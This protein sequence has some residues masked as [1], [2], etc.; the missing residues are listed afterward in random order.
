MRRELLGRPA[1]GGS[2]ARS[3]RS[4]TARH[5]G[6]STARPAAD[7]RRVLREG[8]RLED[9]AA[10]GRST[11]A[12]SAPPPS[13]RP[14]NT[15]QRHP[16]PRPSNRAG[17]RTTPRWRARRPGPGG[18]RRELHRRSAPR[19]CAPWPPRAAQSG[20]PSS[21]HPPAA[22]RH[23]LDDHARQSLRTSAISSP[24]P[25]DG[26]ASTDLLH[27]RLQAGAVEHGLR[28]AGAASGS[29]R[30]R[31][32]ARNMSSEPW[33]APS[34]SQPGRASVHGAR[35]THRRARGLR[36]VLAKR[37]RSRWGMCRQCAPPARSRARWAALGWSSTRLARGIASSTRG[38]PWPSSIGPAPISR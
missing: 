2:P 36:T 37:R 6:T 21:G 32:R 27:A 16:R 14:P 1:R 10:L 7:R 35:D 26:S 18:T 3:A 23:R 19:R 12:G 5:S 28:P 4:S 29:A 11:W 25:A 15:A 9:V 38:W 20:F 17:P 30:M 13:A 24:P 34:H 33:K 8:A 31:R 22:E